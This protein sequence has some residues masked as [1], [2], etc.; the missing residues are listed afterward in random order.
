M[1]A[2]AI[3]ANTSTFRAAPFRTLPAQEVCLGAVE[4]IPS[5]Q[6]RAFHVGSEAIAVFRQ[7]NGKL[8]AI[9]NVCPHRGGPLAEGILG[10]GTVLCPFHAW[11]IRLDTGECQTDPCTL[12]TYAVREEGGQIYL[13]LP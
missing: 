12:Q 8:Y 3:I 13:R 6:G 9:Q 5:G 2:P 4:A 1:A 10:A 7:R 11:K